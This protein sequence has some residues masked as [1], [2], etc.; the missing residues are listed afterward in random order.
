VAPGTTP[1]DAGVLP[2]PCVFCPSSVF[3]VSSG[4]VIQLMVER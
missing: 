1:E 3:S 4:L 2:N